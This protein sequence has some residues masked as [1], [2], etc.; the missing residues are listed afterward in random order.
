MEFRFKKA[1]GSA[2][3]P[4][5]VQRT[6]H[7]GLDAIKSVFGVCEQQTRWPACASAQSDQPFCYSLIGSKYHM[8][9]R[10]ASTTCK[11]SVLFS[12]RVSVAEE[13]GLS[14]T[15]SETPKT[16]FVASRH[17]L[18]KLWLDVTHWV[19]TYTGYC[20]KMS[21]CLHWIR[22]NTHNEGKEIWNFSYLILFSVLGVCRFRITIC[23]FSKLYAW[24]GIKH[25]TW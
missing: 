16:G 4:M 14:P 2:T 25:W 11:H 9:S 12:I 6:S 22:K 3:Y 17:Y 21:R 10:L 24:F 5:W 8:I 19:E 15:L 23:I 20:S 18:I 1:F 13:T 7:N